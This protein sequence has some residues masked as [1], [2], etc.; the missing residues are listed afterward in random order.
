MLTFHRLGY[1]NILSTGN[2]W[3]QYEL[4][5]HPHTLIVGTNGVGKSTMIDAL[6]FGLY[7]KPLR[8]INKPTLVNTTN[9]RELLVEVEFSTQA[10]RYLVRRGIKPSV[11]EIFCNGVAVRSLPSTAEMQEYLEKYVLRCNMKAFTQVVILG[12]SSYVPFMRLTPAARREILEDVLDIEVFSTMFTLAKAR[13]TETKD[14]VVQ[15]QQQVAMIRRQMDVEA[16]YRQQW[17]ERGRETI[18]RIDGELAD[19]DERIATA[20]TQKAELDAQVA[21]L[22]EGR[23]SLIKYQGQQ[24]KAS[25]LVTRTE[26]ERQQA[27]R[28]RDAYAAQ[29]TCPT[30]QQP[31]NPKTKAAKLQTMED[32]CVRLAA[33][34]TEAR[35]LYE[36]IAAKLQAARGADEEYQKADR[37]RL[38]CDT[39]LQELRRNR[40]RL[41]SERD[42]ASTP[43]VPP[44]SVELPSLED[45]EAEVQNW[46]EQKYIAEQCHALLKD[47]GIRTKIVQHYLPVINH[48]VNHYLTLLE[49]SIQFTLDDQFNETI[50]SRYRD[51]FSYENFSEGEKKRIDLALLL[52]WRAIAQMKNSVHTNLL[53]FDEILDSSL[54]FAGMDN[55]IQII[56]QM[57]TTNTFVISHKESMQDRFSRTL[58][59]TRVKGFSCVTEMP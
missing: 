1:K 36:E 33:K 30:C 43:M 21:P 46:A 49:F 27:E 52:T 50:R 41:V 25:T 23:Q 3:T 12:S 54:D 7:G 37:Q 53:I 8:N 2:A 44:P 29:D 56:E 22:R 15:A 18:A 31:I 48:W 40:Q 34:E 28:T 10:N 24:M 6:C 38:L 47:N 59:V 35:G 51:V 55:F 11:F 9:E 19:L 4:D 26:T 58:H 16:A 20:M 17:E 39:T 45:A 32:H 14:A 57:Q 42:A 5:T 13:L